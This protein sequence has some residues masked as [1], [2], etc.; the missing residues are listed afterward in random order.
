MACWLLVFVACG[1]HWD[2]Q[3]GVW[4]IVTIR[5]PKLI[6][7]Q[8]SDSPGEPVT[9][10]YGVQGSHIAN[11]P[12]QCRRGDQFSP[13]GYLRA[14]WGLLGAGFIAN[15]GQMVQATPPGLHPWLLIV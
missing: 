5:E 6:N 2:T 4:C 11:T 9:A 8:P 3:E 12:M 10:V 13:F 7:I 1:L 14:T 15:D